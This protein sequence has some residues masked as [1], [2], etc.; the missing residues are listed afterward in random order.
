MERIAPARPRLDVRDLQIV[1]ALA[2]AG[3]TASACSALHLTQS[4]VSRALLQAEEK[5]GVRLFER[6]ARGLAPTPAGERLLGG[7]RALLAQLTEL[8]AHVAAPEAEPT[9][10]RLVCECY[11]AYRWLPS[12]LARLRR[13]LPGLE[14][15]LAIEHTQDPVAALVAGDIDVA[16]LTTAA[17]RGGVQELPLFSDEIVFVIA[18]SHPLAAR[19]SLTQRDLCENPL[20]TSN[21]PPSEARWFL[22]S[23]FGRRRP[24]LNFVRF[25][26][27][28]AVVDAARAGMG[29]AVLSEWMASVY[30]G[31]GDVVARRLAS[32]PL[33]RPWRIAFR[34]EAA[35]A[36]RRLAG[37]LEGAAPRIDVAPA[38]PAGGPRIEAA[39]SGRSVGPRTTAG[40]AAREAAPRPRAREA[41]RPSGRFAQR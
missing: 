32:G 38:E 26:L 1:L 17:V 4:A 22:A 41:H 3:S 18:P 13:G 28:E 9:R 6:T 21:T 34:R 31:A 24:K 27:T 12:A 19:P 20:I 7:A 14:V 16:L 2:A 40:R 33:Q 37:A 25:P 39:R 30:L 11:T 23:V 8:E 35:A 5:L 29:V 10:V 36:A 15:T